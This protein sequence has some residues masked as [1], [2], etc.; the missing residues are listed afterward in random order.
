MASAVIAYAVMAALA[1]LLLLAESPWWCVAAEAVIVVSFIINIAILRKAY[2]AKGFALREHDITYRSG[3]IFP[4][5]TTVPFSRIQ[6]VSICQNPV[7]KFFGLY[8]IDIDN[9]AQGM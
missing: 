2:Q 6:Q 9:G 8:S 7:S 4:K 1:L 3:V 5:I